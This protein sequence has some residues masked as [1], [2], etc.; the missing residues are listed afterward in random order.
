MSSP[1]RQISAA[2]LMVISSA[3]KRA[4]ISGIRA[5]NFSRVRM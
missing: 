2:T 4:A 1:Y 5:V 3:S